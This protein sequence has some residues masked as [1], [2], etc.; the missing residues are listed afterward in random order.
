MNIVN[1]YFVYDLYKCLL[2]VWIRFIE[3]VWVVR[4]NMLIIN[5]IK[6][7]FKLFVDVVLIIVLTIENR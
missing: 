3:M 7:L 2:V 4:I 5:I 1:L 6:L